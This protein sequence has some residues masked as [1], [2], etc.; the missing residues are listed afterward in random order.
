MQEVEG[1]RMSPALEGPLACCRV[2]H[3]CVVYPFI[4]VGGI[5]MVL[6]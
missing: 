4:R 1:R 2:R 6:R 3:V 5:E